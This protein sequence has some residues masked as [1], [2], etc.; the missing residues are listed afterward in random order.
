MA[1]IKLRRDTAQNWHDVNPILAQGEPGL[2]TDTRKIKYGDGTTHWNLLDYA[3]GSNTNT[4]DYSTGFGDGINDNTWHFVEIDGKKEFDFETQG[5]KAFEITLTD[6]MVA[7][8]ANGNLTFT[9][10]NTPLMDEV[11]LTYGRGNQIYLYTKADYDMNNLSSFYTDMTNP[12]PGV[13]VFPSAPVP[14]VTGDKIV[15]KFWTE[16]TTYTGGNYD[17]NNGFIPDI[18]SEGPTNEVVFDSNEYPWNNWAAFA[19]PDYV[20]KHGL[21]FENSAQGDNRNITAVVNNG[22]GI[23]TATFDGPATQVSTLIETTFTFTSAFLQN[24]WNPT[25]PL[26][27]YPNFDKEC[28]Y[29]YNSSQTNKYTGGVQRSGWIVVNGTTTINFGWYNSYD[30]NNVPQ[31]YLFDYYEIQPG[32]S[33]EVHFYKQL[34][35]VTLSVYA[36]NV[37][38][39]NNG[40]KWF[41]WKDDIAT[42]YSPG[43]TNG[44]LS[45]RCRFIMKNYVAEENS[46]GLISGEFGWIGSGSATQSPYDP[47]RRDN[48]SNWGD[49]ANYNAYPFYHFDTNGIA[50][51][52]DNQKNGSFSRVM[53]VR[54]MYRFNLEI[55]ED[56]QFWYC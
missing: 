12:T 25:I 53:K 49:S 17:V 6:A 8:I 7:D 11:W 40:Y 2:E 52:S 21:V 18:T 23:Y 22:E 34:T 10:A 19:N 20:A 26:D 45:G 5:Y 14:F 3:A 44:I 42:E 48:M 47:Y 32:D 1:K 41:D 50:F 37:N 55:G 29:G 35:M 4:G 30:S 38:N 16:G 31:L 9:S 15:C 43:Q 51:N 13:Y 54:I 46:F 36:P 28:H 27:V 24:G 39:W 33:V 56:D